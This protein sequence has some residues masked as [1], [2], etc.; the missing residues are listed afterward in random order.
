MNIYKKNLV[1]I[2]SFRLTI[3]TFNK[4]ALS[5]NL[6]TR[7]KK[8][9][10]NFFFLLISTSYCSSTRININKNVSRSFV[11][12]KSPFHYKTP[13]HHVQYSYYTAIIFLKTNLLY[14]QEVYEALSSFF[15]LTKA[16]RLQTGNF[17]KLN[18]KNLN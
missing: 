18:I 16:H 12:L 3:N 14:K 11:I 17:K 5:A 4:F 8:K 6:S 10:F 13:K 1:E 15:I 2:V 9:M 7:N